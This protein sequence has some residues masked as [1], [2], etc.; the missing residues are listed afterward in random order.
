MSYDSDGEVYGFGGGGS[1]AAQ[2]AM[3]GNVNG[4]DW[5][6]TN[7][8]G[9]VGTL[10]EFY[11]KYPGPWNGWSSPYEDRLQAIQQQAR[12]AY[13]Q[14]EKIDAM[15][16]ARSDLMAVRENLTPSQFDFYRN[17]VEAGNLQAMNEIG[18]NSAASRMGRA[19]P[20]EGG[21]LSNALG[22][23]FGADKIDVVTPDENIARGITSGYM[24][25]DPEIDQIKGT[26]KAALAPFASTFQALAN[27][28][29]PGLGMLGGYVARKGLDAAAAYSQA[30]GGL[31]AGTQT[32]ASLG[33]GMLTG[34][35]ASPMYGLVDSFDRLANLGGM[36]ADAGALPGRTTPTSAANSE[37]DRINYYL[38]LMRSAY[39]G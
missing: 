10:D 4:G 36:L 27:I 30:P 9:R 26:W 1:N 3:G 15:T 19:M 31:P 8:T 38:S 14:Q 16:Q 22:S 28:I 17:A 6:L 37:Q 12:S 24:A 35:D 20:A 25:Y 13:A 2:D 5:S 32:L 21:F 18:L 29:S 11:D 34:V 39:N 23:L 33:T 7:L